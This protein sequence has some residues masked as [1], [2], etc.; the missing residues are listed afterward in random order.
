VRAARAAAAFPFR[1]VP[2]A[3]YVARYGAD[4]SGF[5]Y[6]DYAYPDADLQAWLDEVGRL[7][8]E[9]PSEPDR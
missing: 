2:P 3:E 6:D 7:L 8:R 5:T 1:R 9:R 4:M